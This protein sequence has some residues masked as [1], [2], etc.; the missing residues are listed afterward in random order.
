MTEKLDALFDWSYLLILSSF[1]NAAF[2]HVC[3][4][5]QVE[6]AMEKSCFLDTCTLALPLPVFRSI[7]RFA[8]STN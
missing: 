8:T 6:L 3:E 5:P 7:Q 1:Y 4:R 2:P